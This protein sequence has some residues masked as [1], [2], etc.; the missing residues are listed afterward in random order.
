MPLQ[1]WDYWGITEEDWVAGW[2]RTIRD[3]LDA[4][5]AGKPTDESD[6][7]APEFEVRIFA[8]RRSDNAV[9]DYRVAG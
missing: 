6:T 4:G 3:A 1:P 5:F 7:P 2:R 9:H 8:R